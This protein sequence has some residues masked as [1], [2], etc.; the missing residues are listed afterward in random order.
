MVVTKQVI[1]DQLNKPYY[2]VCQ[3]PVINIQANFQ[4]KFTSKDYCLKIT[5]V[6]ENK[7]T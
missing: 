2:Q 4:S 1:E 3:I 5:A 6:L 7:N